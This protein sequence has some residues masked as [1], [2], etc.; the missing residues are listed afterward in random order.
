MSVYMGSVYTGRIKG[1]IDYTECG[2]E[3]I[4]TRC[5]WRYLLWTLIWLNWTYKTSV[6]IWMYHSRPRQNWHTSG[7]LQFASETWGAF[8][9]TKISEISGPK[10]NGTVKIPGKV[11]ENLGIR[12]ECTLFDGISGIIEISGLVSLPSVNWRGHLK[13]NNITAAG[14]RS[15]DMVPCL[16]RS[17]GTAVIIYLAKLR[18]ARERYFLCQ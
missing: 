9:S 16:P 15:N 17:K 1:H 11:F 6:E 14:R 18:A 13:S 2:V 10:L 7:T 5:C 4:C 12:F 3:R 8:H